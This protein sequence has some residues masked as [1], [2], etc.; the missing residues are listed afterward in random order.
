MLEWI[1]Q[2]IRS[3]YDLN[4]EFTGSRCY[5]AAKCHSCTK[6]YKNTTLFLLVFCSIP[7]LH[8][9]LF[10]PS[11]YSGHTFSFQAVITFQSPILFFSKKPIRLSFSTWCSGKSLEILGQPLEFCLAWLWGLKRSQTCTTT[12]SPV[13]KAW[14]WSSLYYDYWVGERSYESL[15]V[16]HEWWGSV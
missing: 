11:S 6:C 3:M 13:K 7:N 8:H 9:S 15:D 10:Y 1:N 12:T 4:K 16:P 14:T 5:R 2:T